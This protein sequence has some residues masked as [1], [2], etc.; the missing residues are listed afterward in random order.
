[1]DIV[2]STLFTGLVSFGTA[3]LT[4]GNAITESLDA[5]Y[6]LKI[7]RKT[8]E[9]ANDLKSQYEK[10]RTNPDNAL[11]Q[12][13]LDEMKNQLVQIQNDQNEFKQAVGERLAK[14][15]EENLKLPNKNIASPTMEATENYIQDKEIRDMFAA[16]L[17]SSADR[18]KEH[19]VRPAF[20]QIIKE[21]SPI[22]SKILATLGRVEP[23]AR[24]IQYK[25]GESQYRVV[26]EGIIPGS[27]TFG[28]PNMVASSLYNLQRL[29][30]IDI[31]Y[32]LAVA[33][34]SRYDDLKTSIQFNQVQ[35]DNPT[36][37]LQ[38]G[39]AAITPFGQDFKAA[40]LY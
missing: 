31:K 38:L 7:G 4:H 1:M 40:V 23:V 30:L 17:A 16:L 12:P 37:D 34:E 22:D 9:Q 28:T 3:Y 6:Y 14:I 11:P 8:I 2:L 21:M 29:G 15:S 27:D 25:E 24:I 5:L 39:S 10:A 13:M 35:K 32:D 36:L 20:V 26:R 19:F 33:N 18:S